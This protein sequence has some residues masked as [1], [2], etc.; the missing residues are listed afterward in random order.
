VPTVPLLLD[1]V[2]LVELVVPLVELVVPLVL[3][4][5][6]LVELVVPLVLVV[7]PL[8]LLVVPIV[9]LVLDVVPLVELV[10]PLV[11][12]V[13]PLV[14]VVVALVL[15]VAPR[16]PAASPQIKS[17]AA[18]RPAALRRANTRRGWALSMGLGN[19][20]DLPQF[21]PPNAR[22]KMRG[23][24][25]CAG[26]PRPGKPDR[27]CGRPRAAQQIFPFPFSAGSPPFRPF[28][29]FSPPAAHCLH[30][31]SRHAQVQIHP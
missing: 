8:V 12:L 18:K 9:P 14:L 11:L 17:S 30:P 10:V 19:G 15:E 20:R 13:V 2:P 25:G 1:V 3:V 26:P 28:Q 29:L 5:V 23:K 31:L 21:A 7:V 22:P 16:R 27:G 24:H 4:V 6:P